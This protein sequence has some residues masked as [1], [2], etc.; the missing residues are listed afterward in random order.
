MDFR[1]LILS[2]RTEIIFPEI[3][4]LISL[5][6]TVFLDLLFEKGSFRNIYQ[7]LPFIGILTSFT[8]L[9]FQWEAGL[10]E[11]FEDQQ[12][13]FLGS[14]RGDELGILF[15]G[16]IALS[17]F[18]SLLLSSEYIEKSGTA[19]LEFYSLFVSAILGGMFLA[20][21]NDLITLFVSL[22][23][24]GLS[25]YLLTGYMKRD[26]RSNEAGLKYLLIG[27]ASSAILLYGISWLYGIS[28]GHLEFH[29]LL[30][31]CLAFDLTSSVSCWV[32]FFFI[33]VGLA[34]KL[35]AA[36]FHQWTPDVYQGA[37]TPMVAFLSVTSKAAGLALT[38]RFLTL[39]FPY[40][41][42]EWHF[43]FEILACLSMGIG[44]LVAL[45][46]TSFKRMLGYSSV[47]QAGYLMIGLITGEEEGYASLLIY[48]FVY[49][50]MNLGAF[51]GAILFGLRTGTDQI[52]DFSGLYKKD[53]ALTA[54]LSVAL[55][56]LGGIPPLAGFFGKIYIFWAGWKAGYFFLVTFALVTS[57]ISIYYY[58]RVV[59]I[60]FV[61]D[62]LSLINYPISFLPKKPIEFGMSF[63]TFGSLF[64]GIFLN[65]ILEGVER[66]LE[67][68]PYLQNS[69]DYVQTLSF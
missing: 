56:S 3:L 34:F 61:K 22:E 26:I 42:T 68:T 37:P 31:S 39:I 65:P 50:L 29:S 66:S 7:W 58:L 35:S 54:G 41:D 19:K 10:N 48:L 16:F 14:L 59:K 24:L 43:F 23:T 9:V 64:V 25:S 12:I 15:R 60:M 13:S 11:S 45:T 2:L 21:S 36:P 40:L 17:G 8:A 57:V 62:S 1:D 44:N 47:G 5:L 6:I 46:Q 32:A 28:G 20:G 18:F 55:L 49:L 33:T 38:A 30:A 67:V 53:P 69:F 27:A 63:C 51:A 4:L 52:K